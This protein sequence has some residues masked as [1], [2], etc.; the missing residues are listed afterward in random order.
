MEY[1]VTIKHTLISKLLLSFGFIVFNFYYLKREK[2]R[3][4]NSIVVCGSVS[5]SSR[6]KRE[7]KRGREEKKRNDMTILSSLLSYYFLS[8][9][10]YR[11]CLGEVL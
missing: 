3:E 7:R 6:M 5:M 2:M 8:S 4:R 9:P 1:D 11:C 10:P